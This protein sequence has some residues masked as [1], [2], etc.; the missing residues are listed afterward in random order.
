MPAVPATIRDVPVLALAEKLGTI[1]HQKASTTRKYG[2]KGK[3][4]IAPGVQFVPYPSTFRLG[5]SKVVQ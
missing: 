1:G 5:D 3:A 2:R 4:P